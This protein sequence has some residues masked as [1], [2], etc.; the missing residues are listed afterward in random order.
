MSRNATFD[1]MKGIG[2]LAVIAGHCIIPDMLHRFIYMW[3][4]PLFFFVSGYFYRPKSAKDLVDNSLRG[5]IVP[6][7]ITFSIIL[8]ITLIKDLL[9]NNNDTLRRLLGMFTIRY[10]FN[11]AE[12]KYG[13]AGALWFLPALFWCRV[14]YAGYSRFTSSQ[15]A[16]WVGYIT[17]SYTAIYIGQR[18]FFPFFLC[19]G[20]QGLIFY[21]IGY[22]C[23]RTNIEKIKISPLLL[24]V[25]ICGI[26]VGMLLGT[27]YC[28]ALCYSFWILNVIA[29]SCA[30]LLI[31]HISSYASFWKYSSIIAWVGRYSILVLCI[32]ATDGILGITSSIVETNN[33]LG[34]LSYN[35]IYFLTA[36]SFT[37]LASKSKFIRRIYIIK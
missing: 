21:H 37:Y 14:I 24:I 16:M 1:I 12:M 13:E 7:I 31:Y 32:H 33:T 34:R 28:F 5:L 6:Y 10:Y 4:I 3:H 20:L 11:S 27:L 2:I 23:K 17:L 30:I 8:T 9:C 36:L 18:F 29:A 26:V 25:L 15:L 22:V 19:Q 35:I